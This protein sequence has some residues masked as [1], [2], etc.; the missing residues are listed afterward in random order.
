[1]SHESKWSELRD[2]LEPFSATEDSCASR[3]RLALQMMDAGIQMMAMNL[4][5]RCPDDSPQRSQERLLEWLEAQPYPEG[6]RCA[7]YRFEG[8]ERLS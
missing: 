8:H 1:M 4:K 5:R 7:R 2:R 6:L 3:L